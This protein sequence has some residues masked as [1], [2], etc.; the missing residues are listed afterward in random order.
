MS[1]FKSL[2]GDFQKQMNPWY[3]HIA[4]TVWLSSLLPQHLLRISEKILVKVPA[5]EKLDS[6]T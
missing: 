5:I 4:K 3:S 1:A 2:Q 6:L